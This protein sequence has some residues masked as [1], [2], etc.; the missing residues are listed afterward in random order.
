MSE[1]SS[2]ISRRRASLKA[3]LDRKGLR[4]LRTR[5]M[6]LSVVLA[7]RKA[8]PDAELRTSLDRTGLRWMLTWLLGRSLA[9]QS[10]GVDK[11]LYRSGAWFHRFGDVYVH[12]QTP[13]PPSPTP[14]LLDEQT[15]DT[16]EHHYTPQPGDTIVDAGAGTGTGVLRWSRLDGESGRVI[17]IEASRG[18]SAC[19]ANSAN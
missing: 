4:W 19:S 10:R 15:K 18:L 7:G 9:M 12:V 3:A 13:G 14:A 16:W 1:E 11:V 6:V 17:A 2:I 8:S 5:L